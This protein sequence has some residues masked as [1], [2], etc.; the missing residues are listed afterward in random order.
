MFVEVHGTVH[1]MRQYTQNLTWGANSTA[2]W[3]LEDRRWKNQR[4]STCRAIRKLGWERT[5]GI[6]CFRRCFLRLRLSHHNALPLPLPSPPL[7][8]PPARRARKRPKRQ[9]EALPAATPPSNCNTQGTTTHIVNKQTQPYTRS[10]L[11]LSSSSH[12]AASMPLA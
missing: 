2:I 4:I 6:N 9:S 7:H 12:F 5:T 11:L 1:R 10:F 3:Y 8:C